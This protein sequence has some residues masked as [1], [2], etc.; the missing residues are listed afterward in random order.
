MNTR[1]DFFRRRPI[2][3]DSQVADLLERVCPSPVK[4]GGV[5]TK[6]QMWLCLPRNGK[7]L[8]GAFGDIDATP[9]LMALL[10]RETIYQVVGNDTADRHYYVE[11]VE[12]VDGVHDLYLKY[13]H[14]IGSRLL[15]GV[16]DAQIETLRARFEGR[17]PLPKFKP[18]PTVAHVRLVAAPADGNARIGSLLSEI[19]SSVQ[20]EVQPAPA[21]SPVAQPVASKPEP[22]VI[23]GATAAPAPTLD[24]A[25]VPDAAGSRGRR[26]DEDV[27]TVLRAGR[28]E[29]NKFFLGPERLD[30]KLYK[31]VNV[32]LKELGGAWRGGKTQAHVFEG[33]ADE[34][35]AAVIASGEYLT[36]KDF[37]FFPTPAGLADRAVAMAGLLPGMKVLEPSAGDGSL[38]LRAA[39]IVGAKNVT[40]CEFLARNVAKLKAAGLSDVIHGDFLDIE[41]A[42]IYDAVVMNPPFGSL[43][44]IKHVQHAARFLKPDGVLIA[45]TSPSF[46]HRNTAAAAAFRDF[47]AASQAEVEDIPAGTFRESGTEVATVLL[48][49]DACNFPWHLAADLAEE[50]EE[51]ESEELAEAPRG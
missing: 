31:R 45:I 6:S 27:L 21:P 17:L 32:V 30:P 7:W 36:A 15:G 3:S 34:A 2:L 37:G 50:E 49:M 19:Q 41:P 40:T 13:Q 8:Q 16:S 44:D 14:I 29:D 20:P 33:A 18:G 11:L 4:T 12:R 35:L 25:A 26:I 10:G 38:A 24:G 43:Q 47:A 23:A 48:R 5:R 46:Q 9:H 1:D 42:P 28:T 51:H 39:A 22:R